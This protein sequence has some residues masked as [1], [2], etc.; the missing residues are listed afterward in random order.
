[1]YKRQ[2]WAAL[3]ARYYGWLNDDDR[4]HPDALADVLKAFEETN[5]GVIHGRSDIHEGNQIRLGYGDDDLGDSLLRENKIAQPSTFVKRGALETVCSADTFA[6]VDPLKHY[7]MDWDLWQ[8]LFL[9]GAKFHAL[10]RSLSITRWHSG[11]K[12][13]SLNLRKYREY[14]SLLEHSGF[15][16]KNWT[17]LNFAIHNFANYGPVQTPFR[18]IEKQLSQ[19]HLASNTQAQTQRSSVDVFHYQN[20]PVRIIRPKDNHILK[21]TLPAGQVFS[22]KDPVIEIQTIGLSTL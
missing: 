7:A 16:R 9:S 20:E 15:V 6:P 11:T 17:L 8:R 10:T 14:S 5:A 12:T 18:W 3:E 13:A 4:L 2:G 1:M 22:T 21:D 19:A